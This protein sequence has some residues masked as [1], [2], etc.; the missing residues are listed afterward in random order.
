MNKYEKLIEPRLDEIRQWVSEK[1]ATKKEIA[2]ALGVSYSG[3]RKYEK[4]YPQLA[5]ILTENRQQANEE[6]LGSFWKRVTGYNTKEVTKERIDGKMVVV[7]EVTKH[8]PP[9]VGAAQFWLTNAMPDKF[10]NRQSLDAEV[11]EKLGEFD[12]ET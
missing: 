1:N 4:E 11:T 5:G 8:V 10:K 7:K 2:T 6:A 12:D 3:F 9:D